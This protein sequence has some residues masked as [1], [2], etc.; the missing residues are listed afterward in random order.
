MENNPN[1]STPQPQTQPTQPAQ[2]IVKVASVESAPITTTVPTAVSVPASAAAPASVSAPAPAPIAP[3]AAPIVEDKPVDPSQLMF[4][5]MPKGFDIPKNYVKPAAAA[6]LPPQPVQATP[7]VPRPASSSYMVAPQ[8]PTAPISP[9]MQDNQPAHNGS[10]LGLI[11]SIIIVVLILAAGAVWYFMFY[12][13]A[14]TTTSNSNTAPNSQS[15]ANTSN[16]TTAVNLDS[17]T[18]NSAAGTVT[19]A[20]STTGTNSTSATAT[21]PVSQIPSDWMQKYF[22]QY[23]VNGVCPLAQQ[24][25]CGDS[26]DPDSDGLTNLQEYKDGTNPIVADTDGVGI[27]DGDAVNIFNLDPT[28]E[29]TGGNPS[30]TD[31]QDL[32]DKYNSRKH[33][34]F[35]DADLVQIAAN[36][37]EFKL[38]QPTISTLGSTLVDFYTNYTSTQ[39]SASSQNST[40]PIPAPPTSQPSQ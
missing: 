1:N 5:T 28:T 35:S 26:A 23:L 8:G 20:G 36:I 9:N 22:A 18:A 34:S 33:A 29:H 3:L 21:P 32:Q 39:N 13:K 30:Y 17:S 12:N 31:A 2:P 6:P 10:K 40:T 4:K 38:H 14:N 37:A 15:T 27:A 24:S 16:S 25:V 11:I 19:D 7:G